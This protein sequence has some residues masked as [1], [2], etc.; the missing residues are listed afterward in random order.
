MIGEST[1]S[2]SLCSDVGFPNFKFCFFHMPTN[3]ISNVNMFFFSTKKSKTHHPSDSHSCNTL[4]SSFNK[5]NIS[6]S[7]FVVSTNFQLNLYV[8][9]I[10]LLWWLAILHNDNY[11]YATLVHVCAVRLP[12]NTSLWWQNYC[13]RVWKSNCLQWFVFWKLELVEMWN[14]VLTCGMWVKG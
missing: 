1:L 7:F 9:S 12:L 5:N 2:H 3:Q 10:W 4:F 11:Y 13:I 8:E 6:F 14:I